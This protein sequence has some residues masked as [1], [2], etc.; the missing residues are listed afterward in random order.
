METDINEDIQVIA[1]FKTGP[2]RPA[3]FSWNNNIYEVKKIHS[4]WVSSV[5]TARIIHYSVSTESGSSFEIEL[6]TELLKWK[7]SKSMI[8]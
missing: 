6:N 3:K 1:V 4:C 2:P 7:L 8:Y 5:G